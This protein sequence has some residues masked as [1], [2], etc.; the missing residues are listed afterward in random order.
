[1]VIDHDD[2]EIEIRLLPQNALDGIEDR[3]LTIPDRND[4]AGA[5]RKPL[6]RNSGRLK[7]RLELSSGPLEMIGGNLLHFDLKASIFGIDVIELFLARRTYIG[8]GGGV[9]RFGNP[10]DR[11]FFGYPK[12]QIIEAAPPVVFALLEEFLPNRNDR[13]KIEIIANTAGLII[14]SSL[15][16]RIGINQASSGVLDDL[17]HPIEHSGPVI[18]IYAGITE[19]N[20]AR[21]GVDDFGSVH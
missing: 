6:G 9:Q 17:S 13:A 19:K 21:P 20:N 8:D 14:D 3:P 10:N 18:K 11:P 16:N 2:I 15:S 5:N 7:L 1:M 4:N 12:P